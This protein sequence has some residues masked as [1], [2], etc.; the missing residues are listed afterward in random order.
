MTNSVRYVPPEIQAKKEA[1]HST[2]AWMMAVKPKD[3]EWEGFTSWDVAFDCP[4]Y[5][6]G[7]GNVTPAITYKP[8]GADV[9]NIPAQL[10]LGSQAADVKILAP[11]AD[12]VPDL[13]TIYLDHDKII[14]R[15][16]DGAYW[17]LFEVDPTSDRTARLLYVCGEIGNVSLDDLSATIEL[18][19]Y[20]ELAN[21]VVGKQL[22]IIC[23]VPVFGAGE[24][25]NQVLNDGPLRAAWS[26]EATVL[27]GATANQFT[28]SYGATSVAGSALPAA[29][30]DRLINGDVEFTLAGSGVNKGYKVPIKA[31]TPVTGGMQIVPKL[32]LPYVPQE[33]DTFVLV[34]GCRRFKASC[35]EYNN[36]A[37][38]RSQDL[39]GND[40]LARRTRV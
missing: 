12:Q 17:E 28:V 27:A 30:P 21:R 36:L 8:A 13:P 19:T 3:G 5:V 2:F 34:A 33:G 7:L 25:R 6:D 16:Y 40:D 23:Q 20:E 14:K 35:I 18:T 10:K 15:F 31:A 37:N 32:S 1:T 4:Q 9:T 26:V 38:A 39:P 29:F 22:H 11:R 24:C